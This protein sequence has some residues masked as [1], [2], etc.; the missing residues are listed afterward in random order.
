[1]STKNIYSLVVLLFWATVA[2]AQNQATV[3][4][5]GGGQQ[6][7]VVQQQGKPSVLTVRQAAGS[8]H[9]EVLITQAGQGNQV[10]ISQRGSKTADS[11]GAD[12]ALTTVIQYSTQNGL[13]QLQV[14]QDQQTT[15]TVII[16]PSGTYTHPNTG[17]V[18]PGQEQPT[19]RP[20]PLK[21]QKRR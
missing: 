4:Q 20:R 5:A 18:S 12:T 21:R 17:V 1:M 8:G 11:S 2:V 10:S 16:P 6:I 9:Q 3:S 14:Q 7:S 15:T 19:P 13:G